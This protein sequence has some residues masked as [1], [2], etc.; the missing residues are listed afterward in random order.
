M[1]DIPIPTGGSFP[2]NLRAIVDGDSL[3]TAN[4][5]EMISVIAQAIGVLTSNA[6][7][8]TLP[9]SN[10]TILPAQVTKARTHFKIP[11]VLGDYEY[12]LPTGTDG[13]SVVFRMNPPGGANTVKI[14]RPDTTQLA[15][16]DGD[17][18]G[19]VC[20]QCVEITKL[21]GVWVVTMFGVNDSPTHTLV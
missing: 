18:G 15:E 6:D 10:Y 17:F 19:T 8:G 7:G 9:Q 3:N 12:T 13:Q 21:S 2:A 14:R 16:L 11:A 20:Q 1:Q 4:F 5:A